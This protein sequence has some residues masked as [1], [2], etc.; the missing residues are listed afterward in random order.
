MSN[1]ASVD[2]SQT[3]Y[4]PPETTGHLDDLEVASKSLSQ[5]EKAILQVI[6]A[7]YDGT[8]PQVRAI[9]S[10]NDDIAEGM[11]SLPPHSTKTARILDVTV[12]SDF[13]ITGLR[14]TKGPETTRS[15]RDALIKYLQD[16]YTQP[17]EERRIFRWLSDPLLV[18]DIG[19]ISSQWSQRLGGGSTNLY[20]LVNRTSLQQHPLDYDVHPRDS[21]LT[22]VQDA[23]DRLIV[24][25]VN[26]VW[27]RQTFRTNKSRNS[28]IL[29]QNPR[30]I[31]NMLAGTSWTS[32]SDGSLD[33]FAKLLVVDFFLT[34]IYLQP[35]DYYGLL[36]YPQL[37]KKEVV[38]FSLTKNPH[39]QVP[40]GLFEPRLSAKSREAFKEIEDTEGILRSVKNLV[41]SILFVVA[42]LK[43][44]DI[45]GSQQS[46]RKDHERR[47]Q[48]LEALCLERGN[49]AQRALEAL[50]RQLD[51]L[52]K[53]HAIREAKA[54]KILTILASLY[55]PLSLSASL[56]GVQSP[57]KTIA[58]TRTLEDQNSPGDERLLG[59]NLL[60]DFFGVFI[61]LATATMFIVH[62][63]R[64]GLWIKS[65]GLGI[66]SKKF[67]GP[68]S[69]FHYGR[70]WRYGG[71]GGRIFDIVRVLTAWWIGAGFFIT[72]LVI[73]MVG[74]LRTA[75]N[76]W[77]T[78]KWMFG[79]YMVVGGVLIG[80]YV[81]IYWS[82]HQKRLR[83]R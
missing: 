10:F 56:L 21:Y 40:L 47:I 41:D 22:C 1:P 62:A 75:Q 50:N 32:L 43:Q 63:I 3:R 80:C 20:R 53:R 28:H 12:H 78:A 52:T 4:V 59:T 69:I 31:S 64:L 51:Y 38:K 81:V 83:V 25:I 79:A 7:P 73:F 16:T 17:F 29:F 77:D 14:D 72:L 71:L 67:S 9:F 58:H 68:F 65:N 55:L 13:I 39:L 15:A 2:V 30:T 61:G 82:L 70:R 23:N 66:L 18:N 54:I 11:K 74:M 44:S 46:D 37:S 76:A 24:I 19:S 48:E 36:I 6:D 5:G 8:T 35:V 27:S 33:T 60:F 42:A 57:F 34:S 49:N 26:D 45:A